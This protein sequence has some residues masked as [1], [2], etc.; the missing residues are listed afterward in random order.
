MKSTML[1]FQT[2]ASKDPD[3]ALREIDV[4][5]AAIRKFIQ[6]KDLLQTNIK[7]LESGCKYFRK[8]ISNKKIA[9][10]ALPDFDKIYEQI[11]L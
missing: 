6:Q 5:C 9:Q 3:S 4:Q 7:K 1:S 2:F 8:Q 11:Q 10:E